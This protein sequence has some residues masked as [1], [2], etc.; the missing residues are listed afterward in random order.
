MLLTRPLMLRIAPVP[1]TVQMLPLHLM[2]DLLH[3][4]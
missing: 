4:P 2:P 3:L 1:L